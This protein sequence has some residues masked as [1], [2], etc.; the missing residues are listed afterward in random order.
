MLN[1]LSCRQLVSLGPS[2]ASTSRWPL[3]SIFY[4]PVLQKYLAGQARSSPVPAEFIADDRIYGKSLQQLRVELYQFLLVGRLSAETLAPAVP[5][6]SVDGHSCSG[7]SP[8]SPTNV[9]GLPLCQRILSTGSV[10]TLHVICVSE[11]FAICSRRGISTQ[12]LS[13]PNHILNVVE[14]NS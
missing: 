9:A 5:T 8:P 1:P 4:S 12:Q 7:S 6:L 10:A 11:V 14:K 3:C 13:Q 2:S